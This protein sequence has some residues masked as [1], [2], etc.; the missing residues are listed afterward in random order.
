MHYDQLLAEEQE[1][2]E[3]QFNGAH[4]LDLLVQAAELLERMIFV[5]RGCARDI[6]HDMNVLAHEA[7]TLIEA[8]RADPVDV[9]SRRASAVASADFVFPEPKSREA[10]SNDMDAV[11]DNLQQMMNRE[12]T[13]HP[14]DA[15]AA[16]AAA[17]ASG[18]RDRDA[19]T[20]AEDV[21]DVEAVVGS[22]GGAGDAGSLQIVKICQDHLNHI[23][24]Q[25]H[26]GR[27]GL[28]GE[29]GAYSTTV[30]Q[31]QHS[32]LAT[33]DGKRFAG[34]KPATG[35]LRKRALRLGLLRLDSIRQEDYRT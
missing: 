22:K 14:L 25:A 19:S 8:A 6:K 5:D 1:E 27:I 24:S 20:A 18:A 2:R 23:K 34:V 21:V 7:L 16:A 31:E 32:H 28:G 15:A 26:S 11:F 12:T 4:Q 13:H 35:T 29:L 10:I 17:A 30:Q 3:Q 33:L 9:E